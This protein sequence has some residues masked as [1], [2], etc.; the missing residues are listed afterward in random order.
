MRVQGLTVASGYHRYLSQIFLSFRRASGWDIEYNRI[1]QNFI[2]SFNPPPMRSSPSQRRDQPP[3]K[4]D[5]KAPTQFVCYVTQEQHC[6]VTSRG[7]WVCPYRNILQ[8]LKNPLQI[9]FTGFSVFTDVAEPFPNNL[10]S[11]FCSRI[12]VPSA[13]FC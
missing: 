4:N 13:Y 5:G 11:T 9:F 6:R 12:V 2:S 1:V 3:G 7:C 10:A 8:W